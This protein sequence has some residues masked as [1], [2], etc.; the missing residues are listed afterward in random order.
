M[1]NHYFAEESEDFDTT[2]FSASFKKE[3][4]RSDLREAMLE[5]VASILW[6]ELKYCNLAQWQLVWGIVTLGLPLFSR[7]FRTMRSRLLLLLLEWPSA[8]EQHLREDTAVLQSDRDQSGTYGRQW[9]DGKD[10]NE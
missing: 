10:T 1:F 6:Q 2:V 8:K 9:V 3:I 4:E 5:D 7:C